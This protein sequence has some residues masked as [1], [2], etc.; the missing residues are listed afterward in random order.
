MYCE[1]ADAA[2]DLDCCKYAKMF[3]SEQKNRLVC[4]AQMDVEYGW[5]VFLWHLIL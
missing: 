5:T 3:F 2:Q 4:V 1:D